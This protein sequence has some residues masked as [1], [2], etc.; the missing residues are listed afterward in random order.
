MPALSDLVCLGCPP[1]LL[2]H[3]FQMKE[4]LEREILMQG[5]KNAFEM[6]GLCG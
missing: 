1:L 6:H 3:P 2:V 5:D 4:D